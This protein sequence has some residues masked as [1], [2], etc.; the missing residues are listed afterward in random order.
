MTETT[1]EI[2][3]GIWKSLDRKDFDEWADAVLDK[4]GTSIY[5]NKDDFLPMDFSLEFGYDMDDFSIYHQD[6]SDSI[7]FSI[8]EAL[9][10]STD[11]R[12]E[13]IEYIKEFAKRYLPYIELVDVKERERG[14]DMSFKIKVEN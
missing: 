7:I 8:T 6:G 5:R 9:H 3:I 12:D 14:F 11:L 13:N 4:M 2:K 10:D 1:N